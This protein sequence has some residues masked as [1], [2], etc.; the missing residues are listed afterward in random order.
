MTEVKDN[1]VIEDRDDD[2]TEETTEDGAV[3]FSGTVKKAYGNVLATPVPYT[4]TYVPVKDY[5][6]IPEDE[7]PSKKDILKVV[8]DARKLNERAKATAAALKAAGILKPDPNDPINILAT[9]LKNIEKLDMPADEK[10]MMLAVLKQK[11]TD[12]VEKGK[13]KVA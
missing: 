12:A 3:S 10:S 6:S 8:N 4:A 7:M 5:T 2:E 13:A 11:H 9:M 1:E